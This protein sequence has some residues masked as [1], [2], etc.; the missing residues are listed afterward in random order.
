MTT[1]NN[2][3]KYN[4]DKKWNVILDEHKKQIKLTEFLILDKINVYT[5]KIIFNDI[6][7]DSLIINEFIS[8]VINNNSQSLLE[9]K[10]L[11]L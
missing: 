1:D 10:L 7:C 8:Q 5:N 4:F 11:F 3:K 6:N 9:S 2:N